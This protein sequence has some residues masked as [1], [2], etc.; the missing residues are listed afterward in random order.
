M[1]V[2]QEKEGQ[3]TRIYMTRTGLIK[4]KMSSLNTSLTHPLPYK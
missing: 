4:Y 3:Q 2:H 1:S